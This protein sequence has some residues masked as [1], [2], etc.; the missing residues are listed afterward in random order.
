MDP[1]IERPEIWPDFHDSLITFIRGA[2]QPLLR[3][4]YAAITQDRLYVVEA[5][6]PIR[7]DLS[8]VEA[9]RAGFGT[10]GAGPVAVANVDAPAVFD[11]WREEL[12]Q[13][14]IEIV[15]PAAGNRIVTAM[16]VL[17][18]DN[19]INGSGRDSYMRKR[20]E[21]WESGTNLVEID[22]LRQG[23]P[24]VRVAPE[25]LAGLRPWHYLVAV[26]R[27]WPTRQ[28]IYASQLQ[29]RLPK[30][31][32]PL[33]HDDRD[34]PL[35]LQAVLTRCWDEG[36]YPELLRYEGQPPGKMADEDAAWCDDQLKIAGFRAPK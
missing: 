10:Q 36:P 9:G 11:L 26:T 34:V 5:G 19:K 8:I 30:I 15:E 35:D 2:L 17:S 29:K 22:L 27:H 18:P 6:R 3:P 4:R 13:P 14:F 7:P 25:K 20:E 21:F 28:E 33:A 32:V 24:T 31:A 23:E 1:Y 12:R 16:E